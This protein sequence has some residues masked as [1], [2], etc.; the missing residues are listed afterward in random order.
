MGGFISAFYVDTAQKLHV[1]HW[2]KE[3]LRQRV[4]LGF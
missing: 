3:G 2:R 4:W 1:K